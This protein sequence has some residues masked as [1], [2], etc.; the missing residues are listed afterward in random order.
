MDPVVGFFS[1]AAGGGFGFGLELLEV[2]AAGQVVAQVGGHVPG[3]EGIG[4]G[5]GIDGIPV[6]EIGGS[7]QGGGVSSVLELGVV[8][9]DPADFADQGHQQQEHRQQDGKKHQ[10]GP[11]LFPF[12]MQTH[13]DE[14]AS[15]KQQITGFLQSPDQHQGQG[16]KGKIRSIG[17]G[18]FPAFLPGEEQH[19]GRRS[20]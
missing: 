2:G 6:D 4:V 16:G 5:M 9:P 1:F 7:G 14:A 10:E 17:K 15:F 18:T 20:P 11:F 13:H 8:G 19:Q 12:F 3:G